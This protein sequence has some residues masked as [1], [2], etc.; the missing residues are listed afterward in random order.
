MGVL[1]IALL[2]LFIIAYPYYRLIIIAYYRPLYVLTTVLNL[3]IAAE[4]Q[5]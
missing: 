5:L 4:T 2:S 1:I 3:L